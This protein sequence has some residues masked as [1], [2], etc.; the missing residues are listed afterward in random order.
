MKKLFNL[1]TR[2]VINVRRTNND[3][4]YKSYLL[5]K[6]TW[7][8]TINVLNTKTNMIDTYFICIN[9]NT[10][11]KSCLERDSEVEGFYFDH[12]T[13]QFKPCKISMAAELSPNM[14]ALYKK[15]A[16][17]K[18]SINEQSYRFDK[19]ANMNEHSCSF[20]NT[21]YIIGYYYNVIPNVYLD[22]KDYWAR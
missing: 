3:E 22:N 11:L 9:H 6:G 14:L 4:Y 16:K 13:S 10:L 8:G 17:K 2:E 12:S 1:F 7:F 19:I 5:K 18:V 21:L 15:R 20:I